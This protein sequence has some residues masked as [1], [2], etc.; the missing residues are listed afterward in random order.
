[1]TSA[2][3]VLVF[4]SPAAHTVAEVAVICLVIHVSIEHPKPG[5]TL[6][7][8]FLQGH[9]AIPTIVPMRE[10]LNLNVVRQDTRF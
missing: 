2:S 7:I 9:Q 6:E 4:C 1:M 10:A 5:L 8:T 3:Q